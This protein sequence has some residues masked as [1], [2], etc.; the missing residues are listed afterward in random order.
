[1]DAHQPVQVETLAEV[2]SV[3]TWARD[4]SLELA[5]ELESEVGHL[6]SEV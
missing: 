6:K 1:M 2:R 5:R 3:D 4:Y